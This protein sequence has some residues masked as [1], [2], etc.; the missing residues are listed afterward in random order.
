[1]NKPENKPNHDVIQTL[2]TA[3]QNQTQLNLMADQKANILIGTLVLMFTV[4]LTRMLTVLDDNQGLMLPLMVFVLMQL[5]PL[6]L[7]V[8]VLIPKNI[9]GQKNRPIEQMSNPLFFGFFTRYSQQQYS[10]YLCQ[11]LTDNDSARQL[12][13][14]DIYQ[15]GLILKR[16]YRLLRLAYVFALL[17]VVVPMALWLMVSQ[18][19]LTG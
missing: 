6:V 7:T 10:D 19:W 9:S 3:H 1:M 17:G 13:I 8:L 15:I 14:N 4:V 18:G 16:K 12:L 11:L 5:I 2:R